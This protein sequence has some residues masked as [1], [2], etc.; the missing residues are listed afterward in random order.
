MRISVLAAIAELA[1]AGPSFAY[2]TGGS[3][4]TTTVHASGTHSAGG[5]GGAGKNAITSVE[6]P[7]RCAPGKTCR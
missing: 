3:G 6:H 4:H 7:R 5:G 2:Q 1:I